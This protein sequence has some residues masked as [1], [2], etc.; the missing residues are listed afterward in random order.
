MTVFSKKEKEQPPCQRAILL[1]FDWD[2]PSQ[3][4]SLPA[5]KRAQKY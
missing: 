1:G 3:S 5:D 4:V 2:L